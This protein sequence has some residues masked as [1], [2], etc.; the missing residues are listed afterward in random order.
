MA[1]HFSDDGRIA[2][3]APMF[4]EPCEYDLAASAL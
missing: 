3:H 2:D 4:C 1:S